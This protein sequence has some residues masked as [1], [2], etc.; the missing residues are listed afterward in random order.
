MCKLVAGASGAV[1][2]DVIVAGD[3]GEQDF[4]GLR[5]DSSQHINVTAATL[6]VGHI[7]I[8]VDA[9][10]IDCKW[11]SGDVDIDFVGSFGGVNADF[12]GVEYTSGGAETF[13]A[14]FG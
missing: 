14:I 10:D 3:G 1:K 4:V 8:S 2:L 7:A 6:H 13:I 11:L 5:I 12:N 9:A